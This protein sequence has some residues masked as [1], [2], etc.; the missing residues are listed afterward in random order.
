MAYQQSPEDEL[1][2]LQK[3]SNEY[4]PEATGPLV[5]QRQSSSNLTTE[6]ATADPVYQAKT[7]A[8]PQKYSHYRTARG[9]GSCGW[10]AIAFGYL[11]AL[12]NLRD[13]GKFLE[14]ETRLRSLNNVLNEAGFEQYLYEDYV[15][16]YFTLMRQL[17]KALQDGDGDDVLHN[18]FN[19]LNLQHCFIA[20]MRT[21]TSAWMKTH[22]AGYAPYLLGETIDEYCNNRIM[23]INSEIEHVGLSALKD[24]LLSPAGIALEVLYLDRSSGDEASL[25]RFDAH[26]Y[27]LAFVRLLYRPGHYDI[28]YKPEDVPPP[29]ASEVPTYLQYATHTHHQPADLPAAQDFMTMIPGMSFANPCQDWMSTS[30]YGNSDF[31]TPSAPVQQQCNQMTQPIAPTPQEISTRQHVESQ[32]VYAPPPA[33][34]MPPPPL[35]MAQDLVIRPAPHAAVPR[36]SYHQPLGGPF[37][38]SIWELKPGIMDST[39]QMPFQTA[40]FRNSHFNT[41]H[42]LNP[43]FQPEEWSPDAEYV[44]SNSSKGSRHKSSG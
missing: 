22:Q 40:I 11:E 43:D 37:R 9:D 7:A 24:V 14:E 23:P 35:Q 31:F 5:G 8:L 13:S 38:P 32:P 20:Y 19:D 1:A 42:F 27:N 2:E 4:E 39:A 21:L 28:I 10:R 12:L 26:G 33:Q 17:G 29:P 3:L 44:T 34:H 16:E 6:Y 41:A 36:A 25:H 30:S 15:D 18:A